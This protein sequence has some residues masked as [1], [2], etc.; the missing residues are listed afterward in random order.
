M[1]KRFGLALGVVAASC[2][3]L[4]ASAS[5]AA[6]QIGNQCEATVLGASFTAAQIGGK[7]GGLP[8]AAPSSGVI[9]SWQVN[10]PATAKEEPEYLKLLPPTGNPNEYRVVSES[11]A[12]LITHQG[13]N[14][15]PA[16][17]PIQAGDHLGVFG[18]AGV[19]YC[20]TGNGNDVMGAIGKDATIGSANVYGTNPNFQAAVSAT[21]EPDADNDGYG[22]ETED[23]CPQSAQYF[24]IPCPPLTLSFFSV[25]QRSAALVYVSAG[26]PSQITVSAKVPGA[27]KRKRAGSSA[28]IKL[29]PVTH[30]ANPGQIT[31]YKLKFTGPLKAALANLPSNKSLAL[32]VKASGANLAGVVKSEERTLRLKGQG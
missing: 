6:V 9:T 5:A 26:V 7:P 17:I 24:E 4:A 16:R 27:P 15:F 21:V 20:A 13:P 10:G 32:K 23:K 12:G 3:A 8:V 18:V 19:Y 28:A 2:W 1:A 22:D 29:K 11:P 31:K 14:A 25:A 30:L